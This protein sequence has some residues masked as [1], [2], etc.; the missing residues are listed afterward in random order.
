MARKAEIWK[1]VVGFEGWYEVSSFGRIRRKKT[2]R[3]LKT[4]TNHDRYATIK[5]SVHNKRTTY[6]VHKHVAAAFLGPRPEGKQVHHR[7]GKKQDN[8][9]A[10]LE[11]VTASENILR[12]YA[13][14]HSIRGE[15][16][17][18]AKL[19]ARA[20]QAMR[21]LRDLGYSFA[22]IAKWFGV[23]ISGATLAIK[24]R[25]WSFVPRRITRGGAANGCAKL[26]E[27]DVK[28]IRFLAGNGQPQRD[29]GLAYGVTLSTVSNIANRKSWAHVA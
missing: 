11:Y 2:A 25:N 3:V 15:R 13:G 20:V 6:T 4:S 10:N 8:R 27:K 7:N 24:G 28:E 12:Y 23:G 9:A 19:T 17:P 16:H 26:S 22:D 29:I 21:D 5:F 18:N 1:P 14:E